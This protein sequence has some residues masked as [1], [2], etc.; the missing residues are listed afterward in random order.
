MITQINFDFELN[1][2]EPTNSETRMVVIRERMYEKARKLLAEK[3]VVKG[4]VWWF[5]AKIEEVINK[6]IIN[7]YSEKFS[8]IS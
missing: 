7:K 4:S 8:L 6:N 2:P 5:N 3:K 1:F